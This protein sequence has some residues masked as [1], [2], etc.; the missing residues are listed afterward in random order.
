M[1]LQALFRKGTHHSGQCTNHNLEWVLLDPKQLSFSYEKLKRTPVDILRLRF[2]SSVREKETY[3]LTC[4]HG[5]EGS[6]ALSHQPKWERCW[7]VR[8]GEFAGS[9]QYLSQSPARWQLFSW[10]SCVPSQLWSRD[11]TQLSPM[12]GPCGN[13]MP[14][15]GWGGNR[16]QNS[17]L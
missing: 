2:F 15:F 10:S 17:V 1:F 14:L 3:C 7:E 11:G 8:A 9:R 12:V 4:N 13:L 6:C 5:E 16:V